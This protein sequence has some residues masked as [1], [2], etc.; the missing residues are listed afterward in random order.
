MSPFTCKLTCK[1][2]LY[3][4]GPVPLRNFSRVSKA[5]GFSGPLFCSTYFQWELGHS[6]DHYLK[7]HS[8]FQDQFT[9]MT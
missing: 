2:D 8:M 5:V 7:I 4:N 9:R 6:E 3:N 1:C